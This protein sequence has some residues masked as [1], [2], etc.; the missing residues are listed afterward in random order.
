MDLY[1]W[2][3]SKITVKIEKKTDC[4]FFFFFKYIATCTHTH[5][6][7]GH[8]AWVSDENYQPMS[9]LNTHGSITKEHAAIWLYLLH[10]SLV[11]L[12]VGW[13]GFVKSLQP[14]NQSTQP[15]S[16]TLIFISSDAHTGRSNIKTEE[17]K[18]LTLLA[19][20]SWASV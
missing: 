2:T 12:M 16:H 20:L 7:T 6:C 11:P 8:F 1:L 14:I 5:M 10:N 13:T 3:N 9:F 18:S 15:S 4:G 17:K 19:S